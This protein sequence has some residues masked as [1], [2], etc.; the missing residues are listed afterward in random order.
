MDA[1]PVTYLSFACAIGITKREVHTFAERLDKTLTE[2][3]KKIAAAERKDAKDAKEEGKSSAGGEGS[4]GVNEQESVPAQERQPACQP[5]PA[6][7][8]APGEPGE[9]AR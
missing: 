9:T 7:E 4:A 8:A 1:Y 6:G 5:L 3:R 2:F